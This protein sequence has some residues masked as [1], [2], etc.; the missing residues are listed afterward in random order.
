M[1]MGDSRHFGFSV[2]RIKSNEQCQPKLIFPLWSFP[3]APNS[4]MSLTLKGKEAEAPGITLY[5]IHLYGCP[6]PKLTSTKHPHSSSLHSASIIATQVLDLNTSF[7]VYSNIFLSRLLV[8]GLSFFEDLLSLGSLS[9][10]ILS[11]IL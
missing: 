11:C 10:P 1:S 2:P 7:L 8:S 9:I 6:L 4:I 5:Y 3:P